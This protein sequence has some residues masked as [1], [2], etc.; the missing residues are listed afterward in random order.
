MI[1]LK[2]KKQTYNTVKTSKKK[3]KIMSFKTICHNNSNVSE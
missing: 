2:Y 3:I 1:L